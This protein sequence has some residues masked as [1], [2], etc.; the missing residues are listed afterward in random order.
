MDE[1]KF[2]LVMIG[3]VVGIIIGMILVIIITSNGGNEVIKTDMLT[4]ICEEVYGESYVWVDDSLGAEIRIV[5]QKS[6]IDRMILATHE[7][8]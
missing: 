8:D 5:C 3:F 7:E 6:E 2:G 4:D 1:G